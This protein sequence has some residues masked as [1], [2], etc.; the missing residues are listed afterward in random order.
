MDNHIISAEEMVQ[1]KPAGEKNS[2][3]NKKV[4][5]RGGK[6]TPVKKDKPAKA[7][8]EKKEKRL[9]ALSVNKRFFSLR[10]KIFVGFLVPI[11]FV[12]MV[13]VI[14]YNAAAN[15]LTEKFKESSTLVSQMAMD[16]VDVS[17]VF[18][19]GQAMQYM[20]D[21]NLESYTLGMMEKDAVAKATYMTDTRNVLAALQHMNSMIN[22]IHIVTREGIAMFSTASMD[23]P[24]GIFDTYKAEAMTASADGKTIS[25]WT[26]GHEALDEAFHLKPEDTFVVFHIPT[27]K[28][29]AYIVVDVSRNA[30]YDRLQAI[31]FG[32]GSICGYVTDTGRELIY[33]NLPEGAGSIFSEGESVFV[34]TDFY[35]ESKAGGEQCVAKNVSFR[36]KSYLYIYNK[37]AEGDN[38]CFCALVPYSVITGQAQKI[39]G[40]TI[41]IVIIACLLAG[42]VGLYITFGIQ[43][44][45]R[46][47]S[48][49]FNQVAEGDLTTA[50]KAYGKDEFQDL[51]Q[52]A[53]HMI[54]NNRN[55]VLK[56]NGTVEMLENST[57]DVNDVA[58]R[59]NHCSQDI[60]QVIDEI[61][62]G[63]NKQAEHAEECVSRTNN[64]SDR[65]REMQERV[66]HTRTL[67]D[68]TEKMIGQGT[69]LVEVLED[70]TKETSRI[71]QKVGGSIGQLKAESETIN[72]FAET[73]SNI[74]SQTNLLSLNASIEAA[75]A[76]EAGRGFA[77][78][79]SEIRKLADDSRMAAEEIRTKVANISKYT[80]QTVEDAGYAQNIVQIQEDAVGQV[81]RVFGG[82]SGQIT[83]LLA[84]LRN[85]AVE[86]EAADQERNDTIE[87]VESISAIIEETASSTMQVHDM[88]EHLLQSVDQLNQT[89][90]GLSDNMQGLKKEIAAFKVTADKKLDIPGE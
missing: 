36:G 56:L 58:D 82:M 50:V 26:E 22:N 1:Q 40:I 44:N 54:R 34:G 75:R 19:K 62:K 2:K 17:F 81:I 88:A 73:I 7:K 68:L 67:V 80:E 20:V 46:I 52:V 55:L 89:S 86:T 49:G 53:T 37:S 32:D 42:A 11:F 33:E 15:G 85:I 64:L 9:P 48:E 23:R 74:S 77:V 5:A 51:A 13:G 21:S 72:E 16:Y 45:M 65:I 87:A 8:K 70:K 63:M 12:V 78:V 41:A 30:L 38:L 43:R 47:I 25:R 59:I 76:G 3:K 18:I 66:E 4:K 24:D 84:E 61:N 57:T 90:D 60:T 6:K 79:A 39:K 35:E 10:N 69:E 31:D 28:G 83:E 71:T 29:V 14:A 27:N